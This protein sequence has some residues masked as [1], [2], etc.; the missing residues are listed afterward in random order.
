MFIVYYINS[1][2][3]NKLQH[4]SWLTKVSYIKKVARFTRRKSIKIHLNLHKLHKLY[5]QCAVSKWLL[6]YLQKQ[7]SLFEI[8]CTAI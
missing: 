8:L 3:I 4:A 7:D 2:K 1:L 5:K 6:N